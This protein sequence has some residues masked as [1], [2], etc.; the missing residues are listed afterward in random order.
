MKKDCLIPNLKNKNTHEK[1][2]IIKENNKNIM[3][4]DQWTT[5]KDI[6][7]WAGQKLPIHNMNA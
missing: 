5:N 3:I 2:C 1:W 6:Q 7:Y 4:G